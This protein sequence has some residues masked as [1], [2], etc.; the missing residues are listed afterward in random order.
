MSAADSTHIVIN[1]KVFLA[2]LSGVAGLL[3]LHL[4]DHPLLILVNP[5]F[6]AGRKVKIFTILLKV[7]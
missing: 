7:L 6:F 3:H 2:C 4:W 5:F 1:R